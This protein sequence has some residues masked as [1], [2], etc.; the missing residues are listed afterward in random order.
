M[1][2]RGEFRAA[3]QDIA[4]RRGVLR[5]EPGWDAAALKTLASAI[6]REPGTIAVLV[7]DGTPAPVVIARSADVDLDAAEWMKQAA[8]SLG[9][10]G[11]GR[12]ETGARGTGG[13]SRTHAG[14]CEGNARNRMI[15]PI[16]GANWCPH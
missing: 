13:E 9:G 11:G 7:G 3:A 1:G 10:R 5:H 4:G 8:G 2:T 16:F 6:V 12:P 14:V 15:G